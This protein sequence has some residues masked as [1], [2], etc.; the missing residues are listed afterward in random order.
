VAI[1]S[2][3]GPAREPL[4]LGEAHGVG[5]E[6]ERKDGDPLRRER[7]GEPGGG[8]HAA[9]HGE[10]I[11]RRGALAA[12]GHQQGDVKLGPREGEPRRDRC[13]EEIAPRICVEARQSLDDGVTE[14]TVHRALHPREHPREVGIAPHVVARERV[15]EVTIDHLERDGPDA[16]KDLGGLVEEEAAVVEGP[17]RSLGMQAHH[18]LGLLILRAAFDRHQRSFEPERAARCAEARRSRR[19]R[20][21]RG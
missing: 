7:L 11:E 18:H 15:L 2:H 16:R 12:E 13:V 9:E 4:Q 14:R 1:A 6:G 5:F 3:R 19:R 8:G 20:A 17:T 21:R 10:A